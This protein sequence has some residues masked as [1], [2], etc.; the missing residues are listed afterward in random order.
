[1]DSVTRLKTILN[2]ISLFS[3]NC[4]YKKRERERQALETMVGEFEYEDENDEEDRK[5]RSE[6]NVQGVTDNALMQATIA[7]SR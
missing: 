6:V 4:I 3:P 5:R 7:Q 2:N 1:M